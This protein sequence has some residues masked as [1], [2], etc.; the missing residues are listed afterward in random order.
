MRATRNKERYC[1]KT[2][3]KTNPFWGEG[4]TKDFGKIAIEYAAGD[5]VVLDQAFVQYECLVNQAHVV[6]LCAQ[7]LI[8]KDV[9]K[10][11]IKG[12]DEIKKLDEV[13]KFI[14]KKELEDVHSNVEQYV[15]EKYGIEVGG[16]LRLGI[17][18]NDQVYTD[19]RMFMRDKILL[20]SK[21]LVDMIQ[22]L[23]VLA[24]KHTT[25]IM[26]GYTHLRISQPITFGHWLTGKAYHFYDD[27]NNILRQFD[28]INKCPLGIFEMAGTH[29][30][31]DRALTAQLLGFEN[32]TPHSLYT[33]NQRG[34]IEAKLIA[35]FAFVALHL[36]RTMNE[37]I[38]FTT[39]ELEFLKI[40]PLFTTGGTAQPNL[41]NPDTLEVVRANM[42]SILP[43]VVEEMMI[44]DVLS[45]GY[46]R[47]SQQTKPV[48]FQAI[49][50][51]EKTLPVAGQ[52]LS[53]L[54]VNTSNMERAANLNFSTAPDIAVQ[55]CVKG[56]ISFREAHKIVKTLLRGGFLKK[57][58]LELTPE[59]LASVSL[60]AI[61]KKVEI[62]LNEIQ[63]VA[64][65]KVC[66]FSHTS[67]GGPSPS[68]VKKQIQDLKLLVTKAQKGI[69]SKE[70]NIKSGYAQLQKWMKKY[71]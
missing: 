13:G 34:E 66:A 57:S 25:T 15:I 63:E 58:F 45:S 9:A 47:D 36:R 59:L 35:E 12:L 10:K 50:V 33:A 31:I 41:T 49:R 4:E 55:I 52:I 60:K 1:M 30:S 48:L 17:A 22:G 42:A 29:L 54:E 44:M 32:P 38:L 68:E 26:P 69:Q 3:A 21:Q 14:L 71:K 7:K 61:G 11:L 67:T 56:G 18:R 37:L 65:A 27:L 51:M 70:E 19:T 62:T 39:D 40:N 46:N 64:T 16:Y 28:G 23:I 20:I 5:D 43:K 24:Q 8:S 2:I 53:T 6:M